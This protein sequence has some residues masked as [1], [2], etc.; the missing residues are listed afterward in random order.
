MSINLSS[1]YR[2]VPDEGNNDVMRRSDNNNATH[3]SSTRPD[4]RT[5]RHKQHYI[6]DRN[7]YNTR[8]SSV[9]ND[10]FHNNR[11]SFINLYKNFANTNSSNPWIDYEQ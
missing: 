6:L 1:S 2:L 11:R 9:I 3:N 4:N 7:I 10:Y 5:P 8:K